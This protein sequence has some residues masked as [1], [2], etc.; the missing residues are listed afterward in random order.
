GSMGHEPQLLP[1]FTLLIQ[2][3][4]FIASYL[5]MR[6]FVFR[7]YLELLHARQAKTVGLKDQ[8]SAHRAK[9][10]KLQ[11]DYEAFMKAE[12]KKVAEWSDAQRKLLTEE[13]RAVVQKARADVGK[14][15]ASLRSTVRSEYEAARREL[16]PHVAD[17]SS[18]I[19]SKLV[20][21]TVKVS[22]VSSDLNK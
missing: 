9:A 13:E 16:L 2:L 12:R 10:Q 1:D 14:E 21:R 18:Q 17:Y 7:P 5:V 22:P 8:A 4:I 19:A 11:Q 6:T 15:L 20:G 3:G